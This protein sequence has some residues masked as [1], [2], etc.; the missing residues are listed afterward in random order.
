MALLQVKSPQKTL[1]LISMLYLKIHI[2]YFNQ[3]KVRV[4][5]STVIAQQ[6]T[7]IFP[8]NRVESSYNIGLCDTLSVVSDIL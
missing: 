3:Y 4:H 6:D 8:T 1:L 5:L 7:Q 2:N